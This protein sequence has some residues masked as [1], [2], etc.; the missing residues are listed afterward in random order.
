MKKLGI[1]LVIGATIM[2]IG[3]LIARSNSFG[4][5]QT[6]FSHYSTGIV[7][8]MKTF[9]DWKSIAYVGLPVGLALWLMDKYLAVG[10]LKK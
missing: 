2:T 4:F 9:M 7:G 3:V 1:Y 6:N 5:G 10:I 8:L